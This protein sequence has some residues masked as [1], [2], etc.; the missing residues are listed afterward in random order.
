MV[1]VG[2][3]VSHQ[4]PK[5]YQRNMQIHPG[6]PLCCLCLPTG[7]NKTLLP[8]G[9]TGEPPVAM[10]RFKVVSV[11]VSCSV[12]LNGFGHRHTVLQCLQP[13][14]SRSI[15]HSAVS[16]CFSSLKEWPPSKV[17]MLSKHQAGKAITTLLA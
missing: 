7:V 15:W 17:P 8:G 6:A 10:P 9:S 2:V 11:P 5:A 4:N 13:Q 16:V 1:L 3:A 12:F 14:G